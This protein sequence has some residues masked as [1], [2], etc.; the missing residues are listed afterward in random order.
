MG[1]NVHANIFLDS[2]SDH[3]YVTKGFVNQ[4][5]PKLKGTMNVSYASFGG[6]KSNPSSTNEYELPLIC[7]SGQVIALNCLEVSKI[8]AP[9][10]KRSVTSHDIPFHHS[11]QVC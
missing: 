3:S 2:G 8:C 5:K 11:S 1:T 9:I 10:R 6:G 4:V 7:K